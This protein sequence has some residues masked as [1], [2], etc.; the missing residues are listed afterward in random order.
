MVQ[1]S[2]L[3]VFSGFRLACFFGSSG[4]LAFSGLP[5]CPFSRVSGLPV[6]S[7]FRLAC[8]FGSSGL[9][10][11]SGFRLARFLGSSGLLAFS[12]LP[13]CPFSWVSGLP[14]FSGFRLACFFWFPACPFSRAFRAFFCF[15]SRIFPFFVLYLQGG[16][17]VL[18]VRKEI[19]KSSARIASR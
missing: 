6:F 17:S 18:S 12:G 1:V 7:G 9:P 19:H 8:F 13:V 4:L 15:V 16:C 11:F 3:P 14:V 10:V 2:G 5:V